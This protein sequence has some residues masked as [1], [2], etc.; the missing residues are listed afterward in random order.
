VADPVGFEWNADWR[1]RGQLGCSAGHV[2]A[3]QLPKKRICV[4][5]I[6]Y[7]AVYSICCVFIF[8]FQRSLLFFPTHHVPTTELKPWV[9][10]GETVGY[11]RE[12]P[13]PDTVWL[14]MHGNAGQAS[15]RDYVLDHIRHIDSLY[16]LEYPGYGMRDGSPSKLSIDKAASDA[17]R[18][19]RE[20]HANSHVCVIG[21]SVGSGPA[22][23]LA[24]EPAPPEKIVLIT[25][26]DTLHRVASRKLFFLP[27]WPLLLDRWDNI[28][29]LKSYK[30][31]VDIFGATRDSVIPVHHARNLAA[32]LHNA[33]FIEISCGHNDWS[34]CRDV[35]IAR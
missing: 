13:N 10:G 2:M 1:P 11:C 12:V 4:A 26:F 8:L 21:E 32:E 25:P 6:R 27:V 34:F 31:Q 28:D 35:V 33:V 16:V 24:N 20:T 19:L 15:D 18:A 30:G 7:C 29:A 17:Y 5:L 3:W 9:T 22:S 23:M 14:M